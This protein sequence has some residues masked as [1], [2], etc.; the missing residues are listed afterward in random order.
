M[1][2]RSLAL[3]F[4][5]VPLFAAQPDMDK[6]LQELQK[7]PE[8]AK[9]AIGFIVANSERAPALNLFFGAAAAAQLGRTEEA[10][11][12]F[13]AAQL[14]ARMDAARYP[15][16]GKGG[17]SPLVALGAINNQVGIMVNPAIMRQPQKFSAVVER[18]AVWNPAT[19][20]GYEP[21]WQF[22]P[23]AS[24][25]D[26]RKKFNENRAAFLKQFRGMAKLLNDA[27]YFAAFKTLQEFNFAPP[28]EQQKPEQVKKK[29]AAVKTLQSIE[30]RMGIKGLF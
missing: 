22:T 17:D 9:P 20:K 6:A 13:Y 1:L 11:F 4:L 30:Q 8:Q 21:G 2:K 7:G 26:A 14:R 24:E 10:A 29:D 23:G 25:A 16:K 5:A 3:L 18:I 19:P 28:A 15:P 27:T 12:L